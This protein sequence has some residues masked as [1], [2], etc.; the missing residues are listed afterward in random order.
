MSESC[1]CES[2]NHEFFSS[3]SVVLFQKF[4]GGWGENSFLRGSVFKIACM[5]CAVNI[6]ISH[7]KL[8]FSVNDQENK[9]CE[10][11][12]KIMETNSKLVPE[13]HI[14]NFN[15]WSRE[16]REFR[17]TVSENNPNFVKWL[18]EKILNF[19]KRLRKKSHN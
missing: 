6:K 11:H 16:N 4:L 7:N 19:V 15:K 18:L 9:Y 10:F 14:T 12:Q 5:N 2:L 13:R 3:E 8:W 1:F 17:P